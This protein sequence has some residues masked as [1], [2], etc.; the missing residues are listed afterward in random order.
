[1]L[2]AEAVAVAPVSPA[3]PAP[4]IDFLFASTIMRSWSIME[5]GAPPPPLPPALGL[6]PPAAPPGVESGLREE[7]APAFPLPPPP[8]AASSLGVAASFALSKPRIPASKSIGLPAAGL[9][10][11][12]G[13]PIGRFAADTGGGGAMMP[14]AAGIK[15]A[16]G[17]AGAAFDRTGCAAGGANV[18]AG[19][20]AATRAAEEAGCCCCCCCG[21]CC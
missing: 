15:D 2:P 21:G 20:A 7:D 4:L 13:A 10:T 8:L 17:G 9:P 11:P 14:A 19:A 5:R 1:M 6:P 16:D 3:A 12:E 18:S